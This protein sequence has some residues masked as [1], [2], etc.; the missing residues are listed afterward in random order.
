MN[1]YRYHWWFLYIKTDAC[2][3]VVMGTEFERSCR[4]IFAASNNS[5]YRKMCLH[6]CRN[7]A[8]L[9]PPWGSPATFVFIPAYTVQIRLPFPRDS[10]GICG[11]VVSPCSAVGSQL[12][13]NRSHE[14]GG[15]LLAIRLRFA[16]PAIN[17]PAVEYHHVHP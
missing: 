5:N 7:A 4:R 6:F 9:I 2:L 3:V 17:F 14:A 11:V 16:R 15:R 13:G 10:C 12:T 1:M 8:W